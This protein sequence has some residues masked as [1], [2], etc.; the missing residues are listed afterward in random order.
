MGFVDHNRKLICVAHI[1]RTGGTAVAKALNQTFGWHVDW[2]KVKSSA[3]Q[4]AWDTYLKFAI[5]RNPFDLLPSLYILP[6]RRDVRTHRPSWEAFVRD[7]ILKDNEEQKLPQSNIIGPDVDFVIRFETLG[8]DFETMCKLAQL[9]KPY[10]TLP[11]AVKPTPGRLPYWKYYT[12]PWMIEA[13][14]ENF[15]ADIER[16]GYDWKRDVVWG[17]LDKTFQYYLF[18]KEE[19]EMSEDAKL[20]LKLM[21]KEVKRQ[22]AD[23]EKRE[24][25]LVQKEAA[26][27]KREKEASRKIKLVQKSELFQKMVT[28]INEL[29]TLFKAAGGQDPQFMG[30]VDN[31]FKAR[32]LLGRDD[33]EK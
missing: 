7:P 24:S 3:G 12:E 10:P 1:P 30:C 28:Q 13:V 16:F 19:K 4:H 23:L 29:Y 21:E 5:V 11:P 27:H 15:A 18:L 8:H 32:S 26:A 22:C 2:K 31:L 17:D 6:N 9:E 20:Q 33:E 25:D 14:F